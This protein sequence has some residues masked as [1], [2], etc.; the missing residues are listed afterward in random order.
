MVIFHKHIKL[1]KGNSQNIRIEKNNN[2]L[3]SN[4]VGKQLETTPFL[5]F[6]EG[7]G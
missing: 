4:T 7:L 5:V 1:E 2:I 6:F 3:A